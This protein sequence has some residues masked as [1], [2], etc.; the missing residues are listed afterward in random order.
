MVC[1]Y[2][3][4]GTCTPAPVQ[5]GMRHMHSCP[6][7]QGVHA[8]Q[9]A[10][11]HAVHTHQYECTYWACGP[12]YIAAARQGRRGRR[13]GGGKHS[14]LQ[15]RRDVAGHVV[16]HDKVFL[17]SVPLCIRWT[18]ARVIVDPGSSSIVDRGSR[19]FL[20]ITKY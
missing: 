1:R 19:T 20:P 9:Y 12:G 3:V 5:H 13:E 4:C 2:A 15:M 17:L 8:H 11:R 18:H 7:R 16:A 14:A 6:A 10:V